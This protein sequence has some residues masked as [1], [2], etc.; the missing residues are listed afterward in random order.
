MKDVN[1]FYK[2]RPNTK[3]SIVSNNRNSQCMSVADPGGGVK[4]ACPLHVCPMSFIFMQFL[5]KIVLNNRLAPPSL[6]LVPQA[7]K[8]WIR[9]CMYFMM[10]PR[11]V[12]FLLLPTENPSSNMP[13]R[14]HSSE[15]TLGSKTEPTYRIW[16]GLQRIVKAVIDRRRTAYLVVP[17]ALTRGY[18]NLLRI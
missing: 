15:D 8:S 4:D 16:I 2:E 18:G 17:C 12:P 7:G 13:G 9:N 1:C 11:C 10:L 14:L 6:R 5:A 3:A